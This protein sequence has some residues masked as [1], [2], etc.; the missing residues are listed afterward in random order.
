MM[1][2]EGKWSR[3]TKPQKQTIYRQQLKQIQS[4]AFNIVLLKIFENSQS[5]I[6]K[7]KD[8]VLSDCQWKPCSR[9][10][11]SEHSSGGL[12][13]YSPYY[14]QRAW[15]S[16]FAEILRYIGIMLDQLAY[17]HQRG[18]R[19]TMGEQNIAIWGTLLWKSLSNMTGL[20]IM[21]QFKS[22]LMIHLMDEHRWMHIV[23]ICT[24]DIVWYICSFFVYIVMRIVSIHHD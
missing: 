4:S 18:V 8:V 11:H 21:Y 12:N 23:T 20:P 19:N 6:W 7:N 16:G 14:K 3:L 10:L 15:S 5:P 24:N 9:S 13:P 2:W 22:K 1:L 17:I